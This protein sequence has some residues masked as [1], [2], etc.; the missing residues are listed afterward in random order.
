MIEKNLTKTNCTITQ[1]CYFCNNSTRVASRQ[2][3]LRV[4]PK[5]KVHLLTIIHLPCLSTMHTWG[6]FSF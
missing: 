3:S 1:L 5:K 4:F 2:I 6:V